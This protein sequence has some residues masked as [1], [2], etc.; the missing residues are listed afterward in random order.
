MN[1]FI[2]ICKSYINIVKS[3]KEY[4]ISVVLSVKKNYH[5]LFL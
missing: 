3:I 1:G 2:L 4:D 5:K